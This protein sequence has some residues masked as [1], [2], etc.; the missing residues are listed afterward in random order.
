MTGSSL[1]PLGWEHMAIPYAK[2]ISISV[3]EPVACSQSERYAKRHPSNRARLITG[4][5]ASGW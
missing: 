4:K 5:R 1:S 2:E 3:P